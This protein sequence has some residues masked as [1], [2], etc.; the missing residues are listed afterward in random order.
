MRTRAAQASIY[1]TYTLCHLLRKTLAPIIRTKLFLSV[2]RFISIFFCAPITQENSFIFNFYI[3][4]KSALSHLCFFLFFLHFL[5][6][7]FRLRILDP[8]FL[9]FSGWPN[10]RTHNNETNDEMGDSFDI[11]FFFFSLLCLCRAYFFGFI[12][13][14]QCI[15]YIER[16]SWKMLCTY[17]ENINRIFKCTSTYIIFFADF[18]ILCCI[19]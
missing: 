1:F 17:I 3:I 9:L 2:L 15:R 6:T 8:S 10:N 13:Y 7:C 16:V 11:H 4:F 19:I 18:C 5:F 14:T 12:I